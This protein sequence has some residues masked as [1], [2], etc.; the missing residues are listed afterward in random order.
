MDLAISKGYK[1]DPLKGTIIGPRG[2]EL[3]QRD[4]EYVRFG[5]RHNKKYYRI[6]AHQ[7]IWYYVNGE[8]AEYIDHINRNKKDNRILN[9]RSVTP[10]QNQFN[11]PARGYSWDRRNNK[12]VSCIKVG[13]K[14]IFL[15]RYVNEMDAS[16]AYHTA[17]KN[18]HRI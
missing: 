2:N 10:Q 12:W 17:K 8:V 16:N 5:I 13:G 7:F 11:L 15:G 4:G 6:L 9:L 14:T 1:C 3:S 18:Y